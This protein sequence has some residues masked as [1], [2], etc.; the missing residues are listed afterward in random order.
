MEP[1]K[2]EVSLV[3]E[4]DHLSAHKLWVL[5]EEGGKES[6]DAVTQTSG[7][8]VQNHLWIMFRWIFAPPLRKRKHS[9]TLLRL[10]VQISSLWLRQKKVTQTVQAES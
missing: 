7:E 10:G 2:N 4:G 1:E 6:S 5:G 3:V 8:V 9:V